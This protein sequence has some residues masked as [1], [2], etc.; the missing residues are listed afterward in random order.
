K[1]ELF[2]LYFA[3]LDIR[4]DSSVHYDLLKEISEKTDALPDNYID[5]SEEEKINLLLNVATVIQPSVVDN[6]IF[7]DTLYTIN[8]IKLIQKSN[9]EK[10]CNRYIISHST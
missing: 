4:Q 2:G 9:G 3:S 5:L 10:G 6:E 7:Q 1:V 8:A